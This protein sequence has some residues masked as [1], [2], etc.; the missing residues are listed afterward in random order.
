MEQSVSQDDLSRTRHFGADGFSSTPQ[1]IGKSVRPSAPE[2][3]V[4]V[5][6]VYYSATGGVFRMAQSIAQGAR[7]AGGSVRLV[8]VRETAP[9]S[10]IEANP[11]W[12]A[13]VRESASIP[14]ASTDDIELADVVLLGTPTRFGN[15][16]S[17]LQAF[18]DTWGP[19]WG[20]GAL[21]DKVFAA[22]TSSATAHGGQEGTL[23][24][25]YAT[26]CHLGGI[27]AAPG[28]TDPSQFVSGNPYGASHTSNNGQIPPD[29]DALT[30]AW[31][32][33]NRATTVAT[34]LLAG[35]RA[36]RGPV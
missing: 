28:Y 9:Q 11:L 32:T 36:L 19:L 8:K 35:K 6:V 31:V 29:E 24:S 27:I 15:V 23:L 14:H 4:K 13:H 30:S 7:D 33:G 18:I 17:Q 12:S 26:V 1:P 21:V 16:S 25:I 5:A 10:A 20:D 34:A 2:Q 22:F 3:A